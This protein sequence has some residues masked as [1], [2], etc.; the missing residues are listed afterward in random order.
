METHLKITGI[1]LIALSLLHIFFPVYFNWKKELAGLSLINRQ[2]MQVHT[3][4][5]A[6]FLLLM[7]LLCITS[8]VELTSTVIGKRIALGLFIFWLARLVIQFAGYSSLL[9]KGKLTETIIH[10]IFSFLWTYM[11]IVFFVVY[12]R[13]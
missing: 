10:I 5:L 8:A 11:S 4:F 9:W 12:Y 7:G 6:L 3:F 13:P 1:I 2:M